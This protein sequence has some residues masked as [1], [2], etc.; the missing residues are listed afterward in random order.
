[1]HIQMTVNNLVQQG[2]FPKGVERLGSPPEVASPTGVHENFSHPC[3][4]H[5][6]AARASDEPAR[7][8]RNRAIFTS[9]RPRAS[10]GV[11]EGS[12]S[13]GGRDSRRHGAMTAIFRVPMRTEPRGPLLAE[14]HVKR[15][16]PAACRHSPT[17]RW[18]VGGA[19]RSSGRNG[20]A[21]HR[22]SR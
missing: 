1:M 5:H 17:L 20:T 10:C 12:R 2:A 11:S 9:P 14:L 6:F 19:T 18:H 3:S 16:F 4:A 8:C 21:N 13:A 22:E 7:G 15:A